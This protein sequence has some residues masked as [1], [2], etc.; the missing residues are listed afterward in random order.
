MHPDIWRAFQRLRTLRSEAPPLVPREHVEDPP[1]SLQQERLWYLDQASPGGTAY[2][3]PVAF[4][5]SG[6]LDWRALRL[7]LEALEHRHESL[8]TTF[9]SSR[10]KVVQRVRSP[11]AFVLPTIS[12]RDGAPQREQQ[13]ARL[14][15]ALHREAW[16]PFDLQRGALFRAALFVLGARENV[17]LLNFH[18]II[19]DDASQDVLFRDLSD[20]YTLFHEGGRSRLTELDV[21]CTDHALWQRKWLQG[22]ARA[23]L[24]SYWREHLKERLQGP[25]LASPALAGNV[26][27]RGPRAQ[28]RLP[29][30]LSPELANAIVQFTQEEGAT[31]YMVLLAAFHVL[32][33]RHSGGQEQHF[34]CSPIANRPQAETEHL[35]G[36]FV[37]L[38]VLP[39]DLRG[40]PNFQRLL[41]QVRGVVAGALAHQDLPMQLLDGVDLGGEPLSQA[42]FAFE[43]APRP[44]LQFAELD[45]EPVELEGG[46]CDFD[47][48]L[49]LHEEQGVISGT[50]KF[51]RQRFHADGAAKLL[52]DFVTILEQ[53]ISAPGQALSAFLPDVV[54]PRVTPSPGLVTSEPARA[55]AVGPLV[56]STE[57]LAAMRIARPEQRRVL[58]R[59]YLRSTVIQ[60]ALRGQMPDAPFQSL[61]ELALDSLRLIELTG[62]IRTE[63]S[64]DM[65]VSHF[66]EATSVEGLADE[67]LTRWLR[68]QLTEPRATPTGGRREFLTR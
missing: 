21:R 19:Y 5:L 61:Q 6:P 43:H 62:R 23:E 68:T 26:A 12:L 49:A 17:L 47:L 46:T 67:L 56:D 50:L 45:I 39:A 44:P 20:L 13:E 1:A 65:P 9:E 22:S 36:Y 66:F 35:I 54:A 33:H 27:T 58:M 57:V 11:G 48:F 14:R 28:G 15:E 59:D 60:V 24:Q 10:G 55:P 3:L 25:R 53:A 64:I 16:R 41:E 51:S 8:R 2:H 18:H 40:D 34:V 30:T 52:R 42:L 37:N 63:L 31:V 38:L 7:S 32:L 29:I 4:R